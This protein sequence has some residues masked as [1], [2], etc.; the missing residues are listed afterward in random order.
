MNEDDDPQGEKRKA[1]TVKKKIAVAER[2][3]D[4]GKGADEKAFT[5]LKIVNTD[6]QLVSRHSQVEIEI[7]IVIDEGRYIKIFCRI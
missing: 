5:V 3:F 1:D 4:A 2:L 7:G 6:I